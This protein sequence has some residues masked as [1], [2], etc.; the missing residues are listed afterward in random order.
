MK[1]LLRHAQRLRVLL[2]LVAVCSVFLVASQK[3]VVWVAKQGKEY[4]I[5]TLFDYGASKLPI[6]PILFTEDSALSNLSTQEG[7]NSRVT[8]FLLNFA[9]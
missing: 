6:S 3:D 4:M 7:Q 2:L 1:R 9:L 8:L 5:I